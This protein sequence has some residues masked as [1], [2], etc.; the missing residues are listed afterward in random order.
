MIQK[1]FSMPATLYFWGRV[2]QYKTYAIF[3]LPLDASGAPKQGQPRQIPLTGRITG[4]DVS[5]DGF[6]IYSDV[7]LN[8]VRLDQPAVQ[9]KIWNGED[10]SSWMSSNEWTKRVAIAGDKVFFCRDTVSF[11]NY[12]DDPIKPKYSPE[13]GQFLQGDMTLSGS[14]VN[15]RAV[16]MFFSAIGTA[17][18][19]GLAVDPNASFG[20]SKRGSRLFWAGNR[21]ERAN[22]ISWLNFANPYT[23]SGSVDGI[24]GI[25]TDTSVD[26]TQPRFMR[27]DKPGLVFPRANQ[28]SVVFGNVQTDQQAKQGFQT[29]LE[30]ALPSSYWQNPQGEWKN[31]TQASVVGNHL[32]L[33]DD[34]KLYHA[35][36]TG[37]VLGYYDA[38]TD[39]FEP[40]LATAFN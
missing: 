26:A 2:G 35:D 3:E 33:V 14:L 13:V 23:S 37:K 8:L 11:F 5:D 22:A 1:G 32:Y 36:L 29:E 31:V 20:D 10:Q 17:G 34:Q 28:R 15:T 18:T 38:P 7:D 27:G 39:G 40:Q 19:I 21:N 24:R 12:D 9:V 25:W 4:L 16:W 6:L 30:V